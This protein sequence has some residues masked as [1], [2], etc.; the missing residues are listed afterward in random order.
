MSEDPTP[1]T[2]ENQEADAPPFLTRVFVT[3]GSGFVGR[4]VVRELVAR[5]H[6]PVCLVRDRSRFL[7]RMS[8]LPADRIEAVAGDLFDD[9]AL[10]KAVEGAEAAIHLV[11]IIT[12]RPFAKQTFERIHLEGTRRVVDACKASGTRRYVQMS[13]LGSRPNAV[14]RYHQTKWAAENLVHDSGLDWTIFRPSIIHGPEG[15][16]MRMMRLFMCSATVQTLGVFPAPFPIIPYFGDGQ[17]RVQP[18]SVKDVAHC[19]VAAL[20]RPETIG[21]IYELGGPEAMSWKELY[22]TCRALMPGAK[23]WKP[24]IS[25]PIWAARLMAQTLMRLP[26]LPPALRFDVGQVQMSQEDS[27]CDIAPVEQAFGIKLRDFREEL[28]AYAGQIE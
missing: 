3:G 23:H 9:A 1:G 13:A 27:V 8:D 7:E 21:R 22:R 12:E 26:I 24:M 15:E 20:S 10:T 4:S 11:G 28:A 25:Q 2:Q 14:S 6:M 19:F 17:C 16:F 18:V 5:G